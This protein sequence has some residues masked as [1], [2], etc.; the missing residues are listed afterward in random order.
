MASIIFSI[1]SLVET[2]RLTYKKLENSS[3]MLVL[4]QEPE[5]NRGI[6]FVVNRACGSEVASMP[7]T[8]AR[9]AAKRKKKATS[10]ALFLP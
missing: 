4:I 3:G 9:F 1:V 5:W 6:S 2:K 8:A 7:T 10:K